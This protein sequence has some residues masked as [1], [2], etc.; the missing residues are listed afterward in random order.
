MPGDGSK[1]IIEGSRGDWPGGAQTLTPRESLL[2]HNGQ[3]LW[4][5][6]DLVPDGSQVWFRILKVLSRCGFRFAACQTL[7]TC[8]GVSLA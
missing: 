8:L 6:A 7:R 3:T 1:I 2:E 5:G 4:F